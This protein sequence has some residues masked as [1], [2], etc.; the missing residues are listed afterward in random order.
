MTGYGLEEAR[1]QEVQDLKSEVFGKHC[2][3]STCMTK[4]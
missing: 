1:V 2:C 4:E 3:N